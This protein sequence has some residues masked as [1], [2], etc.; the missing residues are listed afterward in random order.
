[1]KNF[2][3]QKMVLR[4]IEAVMNKDNKA[5]NKALK[6]IVNNNIGAKIARA[7]NNES[8]L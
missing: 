5:A 1:M 6:S 4:L 7:E 8:L 3:K 2:N